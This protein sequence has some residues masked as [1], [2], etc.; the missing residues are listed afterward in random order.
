MALMIFDAVGALLHGGE[1][2]SMAMAAPGFGPGYTI[3]AWSSMAKAWRKHGEAGNE[4]AMRVPRHST[5]AIG[6]PRL[7]V[8]GIWVLNGDWN[9]AQE[10]SACSVVPTAGSTGHRRF[11]AVAFFGATR[12]YKDECQIPND[13][14]MTKDQIRR[15]SHTRAGLVFSHS[16]LVIL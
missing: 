8:S 9:V 6:N 4:V 13:E 15:S 11:T 2:L 5:F 14:R 3:P 16:T 10:N 7:S 1:L 12:W